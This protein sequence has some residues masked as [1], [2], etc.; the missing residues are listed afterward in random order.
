MR[1]VRSLDVAEQV[2]TL[3]RPVGQGELD[4]VAAS[5]WTAFPPRLESQKTF[6]P[7]LDEAY[8]TKIAREWN[9]KDPRSGCVGYVLR[10]GVRAE[11]V[12]KYE[13]RTVGAHVDV[14]LWVPAEELED[15]NANIVGPIEVIGE[16]RPSVD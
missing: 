10:F 8:A 13:P 2:V 5:G 3:Y 15:F 16:H 11:H 4:L 12:A 1:A 7:V 9:T 6:Y 14:Q